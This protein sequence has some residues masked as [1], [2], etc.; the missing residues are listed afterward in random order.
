MTSISSDTP[1]NGKAPVHLAL[2]RVAIDTYRENVAYL[3]RDC[4]ACRAEG[5]Q[6]LA[7]VEIRVN[8]RRIL[9]SLNLVDDPA[10]VG[11]DELGLSEDAIAA[12]GRGAETL[13]RARQGEP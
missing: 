3:H 4:A 6:A 1:L 5:F 7:K 8:G 9:A 13:W 2:R 11:C 10:I 12:M